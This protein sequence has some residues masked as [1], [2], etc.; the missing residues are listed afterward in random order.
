VALL[1][2]R[3]SLRLHSEAHADC[4]RSTS[5]SASR[6]RSSTAWSSTAPAHPGP[7]GGARVPGPRVRA[8]RSR[9]GRS[10]HRTE[11]LAIWVMR[12]P[13]RLQQ[14]SA[15]TAPR[16]GQA[17]TPGGRTSPTTTTA[18]R[19]FATAAN[20]RIALEASRAPR[21]SGVAAASPQCHHRSPCAM[22]RMASPYSAVTPRHHQC[23]PTVA[24]VGEPRGQDRVP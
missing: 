4:D 7:R 24:L 15:V 11:C 18:G 10:P 6:R 1:E 23:G 2:A 20:T 22:R 8:H 17:S 21:P 16:R 14:F 13:T 5:C 9:R 12:W 3:A 19:W